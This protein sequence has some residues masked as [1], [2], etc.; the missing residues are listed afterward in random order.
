[1]VQ[2]VLALSEDQE[3]RGILSRLLAATGLTSADSTVSPVAI[4][5]G[6]RDRIAK[7]DLAVARALSRNGSR[8]PIILITSHGSE[9]LAVEAL[10]AGIANYL[11]LPLTP[12]QLARAVEDAAPDSAAT[13]PAERILGV[14][15]AIQGVKTYLKRVASC[16]E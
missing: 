9:E 3:V 1:M 13:P 4:L 5:L 6:C 10:R 11:R 12:V 16:S 8:P 15:Q 14:S 7:N 2:A